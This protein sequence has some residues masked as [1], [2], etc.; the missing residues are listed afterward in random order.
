M[1]GDRPLCL[2]GPCTKVDMDDA[3]A[4][5]VVE[6]GNRRGGEYITLVR[7][8]EAL[9]QHYLKHRRRLRLRSPGK[10]TAKQK[11]QLLDLLKNK[12]LK[13]AHAYQFRLTLQE[14]FHYP[15]LPPGRRYRQGLDGERPGLWIATLGQGRQHPYESMGCRAPQVRE[16][17][18]QRHPEGLQQALADRLGQ[19][20]RLPH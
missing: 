15:E 4:V 1:V 5:G 14:D 6:A 18:H 3:R 7:W 2:P 17:D 8:D 10:L 9:L 19:C 16:L 11:A 12:N 20:P 13:T